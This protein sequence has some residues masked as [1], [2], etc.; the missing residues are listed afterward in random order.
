[1]VLTSKKEPSQY[2]YNAVIIVK[3]TF[4]DRVRWIWSML[5][6]KEVRVTK[7]RIELYDGSKESENHGKI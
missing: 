1:M 6:K 7:D 3:P 5:T 2:I 4:T